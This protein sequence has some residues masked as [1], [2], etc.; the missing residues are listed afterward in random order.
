MLL[1]MVPDVDDV[2]HSFGWHALRRYAVPQKLRSTFVPDFKKILAHD[3]P[4]HCDIIW[5]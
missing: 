3:E 5:A 1:V 4:G 2:I